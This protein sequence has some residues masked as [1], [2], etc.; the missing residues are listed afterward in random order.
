MNVLMFHLF[1]CVQLQSLG[2]SGPPYEK[3]LDHLWFSS[4]Y[5]LLP[6]QTLSLHPT[7]EGGPAEYSSCNPLNCPS[8]PQ[9]RKNG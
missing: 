2:L 8:R 9:R 5:N 1:A 6:K 4:I 7:S 3:A